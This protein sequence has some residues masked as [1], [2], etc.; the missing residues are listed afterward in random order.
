MMKFSAAFLFLVHLCSASAD[1]ISLNEDNFGLVTAD[2]MVFLKFFEP[3]S[4]SC[5][6]MS[7]AF[8]T[9]AA[10]WK[11]HA[12][13]LVA[14]IDCSAQESEPLCDDFQIT[15]LP[16]IYYGDPTSP[17]E[18]EGEVNYASMSEFAKKHISKLGCSVNKLEH[19]DA[20][21]KDLIQKLQSKSRAELEE[22]ELQVA[23]RYNEAQDTFEK[24]TD[25]INEQYEQAVDAFN[26][27]VDEIRAETNFKWV[28]QILSSIDSVRDEM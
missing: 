27:K 7:D 24:I 10:E 17:E 6:A 1:V 12:I 5:Q 16:T 18:Y 21:Q 3:N 15:S 13:G 14:E 25:S 9:L 20:Q 26:D 23:L 2:K 4:Q 19:C 11:E 28:Q 8:S 22:V